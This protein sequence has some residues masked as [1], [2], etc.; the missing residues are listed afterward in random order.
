VNDRPLDKRVA[1]VTGGGRGIGRAIAIGLAAAGA[2]VVVVSRTGSE[3]DSVRAEIETSGDA[4]RSFV[5]DVSDERAVLELLVGAREAFG[6]IDILVNNAAVVW[7]IGASRSIDVAQWSS[8]LDVNVT[9]VARLSFLCLPEMLE[10]GWGRIVNIS[11][12]IAER[13]AGMVGANAYATSKAA[14]EAH[15]LNL[16]A[17]LDGTG[18]TVNA[19]RPGGVDTAMQ[20]WIRSQPSDVIGQDLHDR[21]VATKESG[22]L[23]TPEQSA[24]GLLPRI[25]GTATGEIWSVRDAS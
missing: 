11:S 19:Y 7:P 22:T 15:T 18:V 13:P 10:R 8:A 4:A 16:A 17:E 3:I 14:L 20:A 23:L 24:A 1:L 2:S 12:G 5:A 9:A 25:A 21:F 6:P